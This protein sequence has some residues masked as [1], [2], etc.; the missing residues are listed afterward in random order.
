M[1]FRGILSAV[2][3]LFSEGLILQGPSSPLVAQ[4]GGV[5]RLPCSVETPLPLDDLEVEWRRTD[6]KALVHLFQEGESRPESQSDAYRDRAHFFTER[7]IAKG[8]YSLLLRNVTTDD[9]GI[10]SCG[11]YT[12]EETGEIAVEIEAIEHL[13]LTGAD[14]AVTAYVGEEVILNCSVD[15]HIPPEEVSWAKVD[16][17]ES[18]MLVLLFQDNETYPGDSSYQGRTEFFTSEIPKGNF[19]L[20]LKDVRTEDKGEY[21]CKAHSGLLSANTTVILQELGLSS[22]HILVL[23]LCCSAIIVALVVSAMILLDVKDIT[24]REP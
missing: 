8:N 21:I 15:S 1:S 4:L 2:I 12:N 9:A 18:H 16:S 5:L 14:H 19:S 17:D 7:E 22:M 20:R 24:Q 6:S 10:Y 11:V 13:V 3:L 23:V